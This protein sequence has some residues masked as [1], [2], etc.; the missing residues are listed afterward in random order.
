[1]SIGRRFQ[2]L[3]AT[4][5]TS[6]ALTFAT[7]VGARPVCPRI[8]LSRGGRESSTT[9]TARG[10][11]SCTDE[12]RV[13]SLAHGG[14][15]LQDGARVAVSS[16]D[17][18]DQEDPGARLPVGSSA[19]REYAGVRGVCYL[20]RHGL[21]AQPRFGSL[22]VAQEQDA[23]GALVSRT[24]VGPACCSMGRYTD[25]ES[26]NEVEQQRRL[27]HLSSMEA[28]EQEGRRG[29]QSGM[30]EPV[31]QRARQALTQGAQVGLPGGRAEVSRAAGGRSKHH[32]PPS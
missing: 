30:E 18:L 12:Y 26:R 1:V 25:R 19:R 11:T 32:A 24:R 20:P 10:S 8:A 21:P 27:T 23:F 7:P 5:G 29:R 9:R 4:I 14:D 17:G 28:V 6:S 13:R 31:V 3:G 2:L 16:L 15:R 22:A